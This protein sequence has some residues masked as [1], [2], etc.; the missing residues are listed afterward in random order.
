M[1]GVDLVGSRRIGLLPW[2]TE[3]GLRRLIALARS[4]STRESRAT[5]SWSARAPLS[6]ALAAAPR[7][8]ATTPA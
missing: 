1:L 2:V 6:S 7:R 3:P 4:I 5:W 8:L